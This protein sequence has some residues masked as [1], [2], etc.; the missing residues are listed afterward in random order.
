MM[1]LVTR[2]RDG[3]PDT[4]LSLWFGLFFIAVGLIFQATR[5]GPGQLRLSP[6]LGDMGINLFFIVTGLLILIPGLFL[7]M[8]RSHES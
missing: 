8:G 3:K 2:D 5:I 7:A 4:P 1:R 6:T